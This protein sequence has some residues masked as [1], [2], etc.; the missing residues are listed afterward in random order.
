MAWN[1]ALYGAL[2]IVPPRVAAEIP[3]LDREVDRLYELAVAR[4]WTSPEFRRERA[5]LG[6]MS[7]DFLRLSRSLA[8]LADIDLP[9]IW[10]WDDS[11]NQVPAQVITTGDNTSEPPA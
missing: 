6:R 3:A 11:R 4:T 10:T 2:L 7:A 9:S 5:K 1:N 8:G